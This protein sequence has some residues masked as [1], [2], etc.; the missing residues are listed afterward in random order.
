MRAL[1]VR[2]ESYP[3][4]FCFFMRILIVEKTK[5]GLF[6]FMFGTTNY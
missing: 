2:V 1:I 4:L 5:S 6:L 3:F